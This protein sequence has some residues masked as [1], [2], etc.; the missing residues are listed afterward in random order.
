L[1]SPCDGADVALAVLEALGDGNRAS[2]RR[3]PSA[4][5]RHSDVFW[6]RKKIKKAG[7]LGSL[8]SPDGAENV[9]VHG[10]DQFRDTLS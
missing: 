7:G 6:A 3:T 4:A 1:G 9:P 2:N 10:L 5:L 8:N